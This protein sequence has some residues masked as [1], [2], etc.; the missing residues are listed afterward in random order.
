MKITPNC[1]SVKVVHDRPLV[2]S[3]IIAPS[4]FSDAPPSVVR[5]RRGCASPQTL[6]ALPHQHSLVPSRK[7]DLEGRK[8][9]RQMRHPYGALGFPSLPPSPSH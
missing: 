3:E 1:Y 9:S 2:V 4:R 8:D 6:S 7:R 5:W